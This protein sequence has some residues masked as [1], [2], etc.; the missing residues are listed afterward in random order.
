[1]LC[2]A[3]LQSVKFRALF[4]LLNYLRKIYVCKPNFYVIQE[5]WLCVQGGRKVCSSCK[6][7]RKETFLSFIVF[8]K[9]FYCFLFRIPIFYSFSLFFLF[10]KV[11]GGC[12]KKKS[13]SELQVKNTKHSNKEFVNTT[14]IQFSGSF[15]IRFVKV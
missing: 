8:F 4:F 5:P 11:C 10:T 13:M 12:D 2:L 6:T 1:M 14:E 7:F 9:I 3:Y 15:Q